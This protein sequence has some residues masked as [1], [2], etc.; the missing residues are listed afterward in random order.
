MRN[1]DG[2]LRKHKAKVGILSQVLY[3]LQGMAE[4]KEWPVAILSFEGVY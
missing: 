1:G 2:S 4:N 3:M